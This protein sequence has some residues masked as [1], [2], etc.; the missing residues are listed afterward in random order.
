MPLS[1]YISM[2]D[3]DRLDAAI[4]SEEGKMQARAS[5]LRYAIDDPDT[6][7][8]YATAAQPCGDE[9]ADAA[10]QPFLD[11]CLTYATYRYQPVEVMEIMLNAALTAKLRAVQ[12]MEKANAADA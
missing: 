3:C 8:K 2:D 4:A 10:V 1:D 11:I 7:R 5:A 9:S 12:N 6:L